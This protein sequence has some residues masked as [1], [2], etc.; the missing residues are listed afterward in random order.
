VILFIASSGAGSKSQD[1]AW[2][3]FQTPIPRLCPRCRRES[4]RSHGQR[5][6]QAHD[7]DHD[8]IPIRRGRCKPCHL[9]FT[10]LPAQSLPYT[11]YSAVA[12]SQTLHRRLVEE[13]TWERSC[14]D[15]KSDRCP[16]V[17][18]LR[19]WCCSLD[20]SPGW[21]RLR[22]ALQ[23]VPQ[24]LGQSMSLGQGALLLSPTTAAFWL[25]RCYWPLRL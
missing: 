25:G 5:R 20:R 2:T 22:R 24:L 7:A 1:W 6:K 23:L 11:H 18:T 10:F 12:R 14:P 21:Q 3:A 8:W 15:L 4:I 17:S 13:Q 19:R 9:S 16:D